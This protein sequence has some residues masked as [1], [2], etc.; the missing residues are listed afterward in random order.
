MGE[1]SSRTMGTTAAAAAAVLLLSLSCVSAGGLPSHH[2]VNRTVYHL[3]PYSAGALPVN[4]DTGD[5]LGDLYFYLGQFLL[6]LEC[7][8]TS[9]TFRAHFDCD[10]PER[11]G[12][13]VVTRVELEIDTRTA[14]YSGCNLCNGTNPFTQK[15]CKVGTYVCDCES[16]FTGGPECIPDKVGVT[17]VTA[18][19]GSTLPSVTCQHNFDVF[20]GDVKHDSDKCYECVKANHSDLSS[21]CARSDHLCPNDFD[22]CQ[23]GAPKIDWSC[24]A[25]NIVRKTGGFWYSTLAQGQCTESSEACSWKTHGLKTINETCLKGTVASTV[26]SHDRVGCFSGC[27]ARDFN[28]KCWIGCFFDTLLGKQARSSQ[29]LPLGGMS[30]ADVERSWTD[31]FLPEEKGGC[32]AI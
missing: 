29:Y 5:A 32:P 9:S 14:G 30:V 2:T 27:G 19:F 4:M 28:S 3:N 31:A 11:S 15:P 20:C 13:L 10:N 7:V 22:S 25:A 16:S 18:A 8:N 17:N 23:D 12:K 21:S 6:P 26:E 1:L 24:W